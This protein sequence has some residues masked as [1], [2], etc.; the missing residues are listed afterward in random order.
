MPSGYNLSS[1]RR[2]LRIKIIIIS[3]FEIQ[4]FPLESD[5]SFF[6]CPVGFHTTVGIVD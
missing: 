6:L 5:I 3:G 1:E 2:V 4:L